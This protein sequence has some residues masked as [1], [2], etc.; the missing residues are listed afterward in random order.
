MQYEY[1]TTLH[2]LKGRELLEVWESDLASKPVSHFKSAA[3]HVNSLKG[4]NVF[5]AILWRF[6]PD[7]ESIKIIEW[8]ALG[9]TKPL[10]SVENG[11]LF[12]D[13]YQVGELAA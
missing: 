8:R 10:I 3:K 6:S 4:S 1:Q 5:L 11:A 7:L 13:D 2:Q 9:D 12:L